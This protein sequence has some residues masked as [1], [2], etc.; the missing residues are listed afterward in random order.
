MNIMESP[1]PD[2]Y[3]RI[4]NHFGFSHQLMKLA[5]EAVE[6]ADAAFKLRKDHVSDEHH[7]AGKGAW[8]NLAEETADVMVLLSQMA[9]YADGSPDGQKE[10]PLGFWET[11][12]H[13][14][15]DKLNRVLDMV[16][17]SNLP[18]GQPLRLRLE[19]L[20][21]RFEPLP[22]RQLG[23]LHPCL[24]TVGVCLTPAGFLTASPS[25]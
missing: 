1:E 10:L 13:M 23:H 8:R 3:Q 4:L 17:Y 18:R 25:S 7:G 14:K 11:V 9:V 6:L 16:N 21:C 15:K 19:L 5:E 24:T 12:K 20:D 2:E 22:V